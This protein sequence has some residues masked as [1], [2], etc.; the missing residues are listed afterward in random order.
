MTAKEI[1]IE[2][3]KEHNYDG[4]W[5]QDTECGCMI[6]DLMPCESWCG[7]CTPGHKQDC[8]GCDGELCNKEA[9]WCIGDSFHRY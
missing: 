9:T 4:L 2:W 7:D 8:T 1:L 5:H 6:D 3:L